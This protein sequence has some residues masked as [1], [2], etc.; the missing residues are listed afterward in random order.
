MKELTMPMPFNGHIHLR[1]GED[2]DE[3]IFAVWPFSEEVIMPN[4]IP[5]VLTG[6]DAQEYEK[7]I[8][9]AFD[10][11]NWNSLYRQTWKPLLAIQLTEETTPE[12]IKSAHDAG[13][14]RA[15]VYP[16]H[17]TTNSQAGVVNYYKLLPALKTAES[18]DWTVMWHDEV[19]DPTH[20]IESRYR[21][22]AFMPIIT[23]VSWEF[24]NLRQSIE[25]VGCGEMALMIEDMPDNICYTVTP[26]HLTITA[27]DVRGGKFLTDYHCMPCV[28]DP[29]DRA[30]LRRCVTK[31]G[32][33]A[34]YGDDSAPHRRNAKYSPECCAGVFHTGQ[35]GV[36]VVAQVFDEEDAFDR[37]ETFLCTTGRRIHDVPER[38]LPRVKIVEKNWT[39]PE[40]Y[41]DFTPFMAG[42]E[43]RF[44][45]KSV[46]ELSS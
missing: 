31:K 17:G 6:E 11:K 3:V 38:D 32:S 28:K 23:M 14:R 18:L 24:P 16:R 45:V 41:G 12:V 10:G 34:F 8:M 36:S 44:D 4:L 40:S 29:K 26:H 22:L 25:H 42:Q 9:V 15:K 39:V 13:F 1:D 43:L 33:K 20:N 30:V 37:L 27:I 46:D 19:P 21:E 2:L 5:P 7:R 35:E